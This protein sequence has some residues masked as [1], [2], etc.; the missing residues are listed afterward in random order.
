MFVDSMALRT[1]WFMGMDFHIYLLI[2]DVLTK[3]G[4]VKQYDSDFV[5]KD[6]VRE[7]NEFIN[8]QGVKGSFNLGQ[9]VQDT[10]VIAICRGL[11]TKRSAVFANFLIETAKSCI[12]S[13]PRTISTLMNMT[14]YASP[15]QYNNQVMNLN[16]IHLSD[17]TILYNIDLDV[18]SQIIN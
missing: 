1:K 3:I 10:T 9:Y 7:L 16:H 6:K 18:N 12:F 14:E 13:K 17:H 11:N 8:A 5:R 2:D 15:I 4:Y